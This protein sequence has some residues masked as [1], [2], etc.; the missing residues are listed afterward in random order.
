[1]LVSTTSGLSQ[2]RRDH[3]GWKLG[4]ELDEIRGRA[5]VYRVVN[6]PTP[7]DVESEL[8]VGSGKFAPKRG[9]LGERHLAKV[10]EV[11]VTHAQDRARFARNRVPAHAALE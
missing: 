10:V 11:V 3:S 6:P 9:E 5:V 4:E 2:A 8:G 7:R 1:M